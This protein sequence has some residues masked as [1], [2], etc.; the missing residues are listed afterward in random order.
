MKMIDENEIHAIKD[1][2]P[3]HIESINEIIKY[4]YKYIYDNNAHRLW[5]DNDDIRNGIFQK[6]LF[7]LFHLKTDLYLYNNYMNK[8]DFT[9]HFYTHIMD[10][11]I[12][13]N[14]QPALYFIA[15]LDADL[16]FSFY[17]KTYSQ[18]EGFVRIIYKRLFAPVSKTSK[19]P[20]EAVLKELQIKDNN[21]LVKN[22]TIR[23]SIHNDGKFIPRL[24]DKQKI[25]YVS[26]NVKYDLQSGDFIPFSWEDFLRQ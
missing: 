5:Y 25:A 9:H 23:N 1:S 10:R 6:Y 13:N 11:N 7:I 15:N 2:Y 8:G 14:K 22:D 26:F 3:Q 18:F 4:I 19:E 16:R 24:R 21:F 12:E 20:I 17:L